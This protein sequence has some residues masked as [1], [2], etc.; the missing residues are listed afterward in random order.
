MVVT[1]V[2][3][4]CIISFTKTRLSTGALLGEPS[5]QEREYPSS[6]QPFKDTEKQNF[7]ANGNV[8][9]RLYFKC[10]HDQFL[11]EY[12]GGHRGFGLARV[13]AL[14]D[15]LQVGSVERVRWKVKHGGLSLR[16]VRRYCTWRDQHDVD[17]KWLAF[18]SKNFA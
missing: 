15:V 8:S 9:R 11:C 18:H 13:H 1:C 16:D 10:L 12:R 2:T 7:P 4:Q 14:D 6:R 17:I 3:C 5:P